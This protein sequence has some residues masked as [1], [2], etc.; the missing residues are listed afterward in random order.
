M[1]GLG[2]TGLE[3]TISGYIYLAASLLFVLK[4]FD[5]NHDI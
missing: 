2:Q 5:F 1:I 4:I 3:L